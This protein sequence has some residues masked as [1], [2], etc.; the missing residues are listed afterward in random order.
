[1]VDVWVY[2]NVE[3]DC[4]E[5]SDSVIVL[6][7]EVVRLMLDVMEVLVAVMVVETVDVVWVTEAVTDVV[8]A[9][10]VEL[11]VSVVDKIV[12]LEVVDVEVVDVDVVLLVV[13]VVVVVVLVQLFLV[14]NVAADCLWLRG[15][16]RNISQH[17]SH[18]VFGGK[19][20]VIVELV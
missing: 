17:R 18:V 7:P 12:T 10:V 6:V 13:V 14:Q 5:V 4:V 9:D 19:V 16:C 15:T 11:D 8:V 20:V 3:V 1:M 2:E